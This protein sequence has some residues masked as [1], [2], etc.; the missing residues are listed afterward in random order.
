MNK[1]LIGALFL[2]VN[3]KLTSQGGNA[4]DLAPDFLGYLLMVWGAKEVGHWSKHFRKLEKTAV[5]FAIYAGIS[6]LQDALN[7]T[8]G[9]LTFVGIVLAIMA[10]V[11]RMVS[12]R[13]IVKGLLAVEEQTDFELKTSVMNTLWI[14]LAVVSVL[15]SLVGLIPVVRDICAVAT[16][17][18]AICFM[19]AFFR[20]KCYF[21]DAMAELEEEE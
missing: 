5:V 21:D 13:W 8:G 20:T 4:F 19:A 11:I 10:V 6:W 7:I 18:L 16:L 14:C 1:L 12:L 9:S 17:L 3:L 2:V 15:N